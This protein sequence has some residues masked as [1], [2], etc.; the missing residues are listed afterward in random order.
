V[1]L[2]WMIRSGNRAE[3]LGYDN[4]QFTKAPNVLRGMG[5][6]GTGREGHGAGVGLI[7]GQRNI[8]FVVSGQLSGFQAT[9]FHTCIGTDRETASTPRSYGPL[10]LLAVI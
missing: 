7:H 6:M 5:L 9:A 10:C 4:V 2:Y 3:I 8:L 1:L